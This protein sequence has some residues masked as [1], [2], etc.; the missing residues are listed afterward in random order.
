MRELVMLGVVLSATLANAQPIEILIDFGDGGPTPTLGGI[1]NTT[2]SGD[3]TLLTVLDSSGEVVPGVTVKTQAWSGTD[4]LSDPV[5][6][7]T[8]EWVDAKALADFNFVRRGSLSAV[9]IGGLPTG[10]LYDVEVAA[11]AEPQSGDWTV[12]YKLNFN[13]ATAPPSD[14]SSLSFDP[15]F[16]GRVDRDI[17]RWH[18]AE[19]NSSG[20][21]MLVLETMLP[22]FEGMI[23]AM[24]IVPEPGGDALAACALATLA[25]LRRRNRQ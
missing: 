18:D 16:D 19:L 5:H 8:K 7:W 11:V 3:T 2:T 17:M 1:W 14:D 15:E 20:E 13:E 22:E 21:L 23:S 6:T 9:T 24:R 10:E 25:L 12:N 4:T